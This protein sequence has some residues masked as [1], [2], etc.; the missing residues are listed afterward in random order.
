MGDFSVDF[1]RFIQ[2]DGTCAFVTDRPVFSPFTP[3]LR[4]RGNGRLGSKG[5]LSLD[6]GFVE[7]VVLALCSDTPGLRALSS[8]VC[9]MRPVIRLK[10]AP[11]DSFEAGNTG[12]VSALASGQAPGSGLDTSGMVVID[13]LN[14]RGADTYGVQIGS[15]C[16]RPAYGWYLATGALTVWA[17][18]TDCRGGYLAANA[19]SSASPS[20][21]DCVRGST[22]DPAVL[23]YR[24]QL[25]TELKDGLGIDGTLELGSTLQTEFWNRLI[26]SGF[27]EI[28]GSTVL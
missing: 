3:R 13:S 21:I 25:A 27:E 14:W 28:E 2:L 18:R 20:N 22:T 4:E 9:R 15:T 5:P 11:D 23:W 7:A 26:G 16:A 17:L 10:N 8:S 1:D 6:A 19:R 24:S 12:A